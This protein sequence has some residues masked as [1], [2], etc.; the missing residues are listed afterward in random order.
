MV[1]HM[2]FMF[3]EGHLKLLFQSDLRIGQCRFDSCIGLL[4]KM[5]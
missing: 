4:P 3:Q 5:A 2:P 1:R